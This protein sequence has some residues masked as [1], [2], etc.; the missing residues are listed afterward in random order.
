MNNQEAHGPT[1]PEQDNQETQPSKVPISTDLVSVKVTDVGRVRSH[2]EDY[3]DEH[4]PQDLQQLTR[5][6]ALYIVADGM[7][8]HQAGEVASQGAVKLVISQ[9]YKD[10]AHDIG[11]SL[12]RSIRAA[13]QMVYDQAQADST[14]T[15]MGTTLVAAVVLGRK[16]YL[17]NVG[18]SRAYLIHKAGITRITEDHSW[19]EEQ[20]RAGLLTPEQAMR[21][22]QRNLLTRALG[23]KP[24]VEVDLFEGEL[25]PEDKL[26]LCSDGLTG[27]VEDR[28][29]ASIVNQ[30]APA[31]AARRLVALAN[32]RG[33]NDN[34]TVLIVSE[35][36]ETPTVAAPAP[37]VGKK[38]S[39]RR[40]PLLPILAGLAGVLVLALGGLFVARML[41]TPEPTVTP[42]ITVAPSL[43]TAPPDGVPTQTEAPVGTPIEAGTPE[44]TTDPSQP[45]ATLAPTLTPEPTAMPAPIQPQPT[46]TRRAATAAAPS[47]PA[48][49]LDSPASGA[50]LT[51]QILFRWSHPG[52]APGRVFQVLIWKEGVQ[53]H[54]G[55]AAFT[56]QQEQLINL[57]D[58][59][60]VR[61]GGVG[62][63]YWTVAV[64]D[65]NS[66]RRLVEG[67]PRRFEYTGSG[68]ERPKPTPTPDVEGFDLLD[69]LS[70]GGERPKPTKAP[71]SEGEP[72]ASATRR[73]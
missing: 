27:R 63:Y 23:T 32:E 49:T 31:E 56:T 34:I 25:G 33:G 60:Q 14:K 30:Y 18:D 44:P 16:V 3:V 41:S 1:A 43:E 2:N 62:T 53:P 70:S 42:V 68:G 50:P 11:T 21:H 12:V 55:A 58:V 26:L 45:T 73:P 71:T 46:N 66:D 39:G 8:G 17:A 9:Y 15:G 72:P 7:G 52:L 4:V 37:A 38:A 36:V 6:G 29:I 47:S 61:G 22:P 40:S 64:V 54:N 5:K 10:T 28:E 57:D 59:P 48:P 19:V 51:G 20:V 24:S 69:L 13:N 65:E 67:M 35:Q